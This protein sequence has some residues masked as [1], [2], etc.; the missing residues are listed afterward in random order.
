[1][2]GFNGSTAPADCIALAKLEGRQTNNV[3]FSGCDLRGAAK[4]AD[5][6]ADGGAEAVRG[7]FNITQPP[8]HFAGPDHGCDAP[9]STR[10]LLA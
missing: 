9:I 6:S 5:V 4:L 1:M 2:P 3:L 8:R 10:R 7:E